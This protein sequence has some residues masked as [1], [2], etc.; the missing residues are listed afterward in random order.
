MKEDRQQVTLMAVGD[1]MLGGNVGRIM[2]KEGWEHPF[3][4]VAETL[5]EADIVFGN[6]P[7][8][9]SLHSQPNPSK[10]KGYPVL[11]ADPEAVQGLVYAGFNVL[12]LANNHILDFGDKALFDTMEILKKAGI[13]YV[14]AGRNEAEARSPLIIPFGDFRVAFLAYS[15]SYPAAKNRPGCA[16]IKLPIIRK[17]VEKTKKL[18]NIVIVS[19]HHG[20]E[21][22][23]YPVPA[24]ISLAH[25]IIDSGADLILGHH[26]HVL[27]GI[28]RY[29][30]GVIVYSLGNF[31]HD[32]TDPE[33]K[34][35]AL[36]NCA[37]AKIGGIK[38]DPDDRRPNESIIFKCTLSK[39]GVSD[40][41]LIP[42]YINDLYQP[43]ILEGREK[44]GVLHRIEELS[45]KLQDKDMPIWKILTKVDAEDNVKGLFLRDPWYIFKKFYRIRPEHIKLFMSYLSNRLRPAKG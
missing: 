5:R 42:I 35:E 34:R 43:T 19:L 44:E 36:E 20:L 33:A 27:Q 9:L 28:E 14:G 22:S 16:P 1:V 12:S 38:F 8:P 39:T 21:Y 23:D 24:H 2:V 45:L 29:N 6:L 37:L 31:V 25:K 15:C 30:S 13:N 3:K 11:K 7:T 10:P 17:D 18:A 40:I 41:S 32:L 4:Y 26:P